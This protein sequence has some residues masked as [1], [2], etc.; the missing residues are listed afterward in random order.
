M[1]RVGTQ[2]SVDTHS[3]D[4][5]LRSLWRERSLA[6][7]SQMKLTSTLTI[8]AS[9]V[10]VLRPHPALAESCAEGMVSTD[11]THCCWPG[12]E[13]QDD[14]CVGAPNCPA[15]FEPTAENRACAKRRTRRWIDWRTAD[16]DNGHR[17]GFFVRFALGYERTILPSVLLLGGTDANGMM[18][19]TR[20]IDPGFGGVG[21][22]FLYGN[23]LGP[24][25][26][27]ASFHYAGSSDQVASSHFPPAR[28]GKYAP[29]IA[30]PLRTSVVS[31][32][33]TVDLGFRFES[34]FAAIEG[35]GGFGLD[36]WDVKSE[37]FGGHDVL[38][39]D[40]PLWARLILKP[41]CEI[42]LVTGI[43]R[44]FLSGS[45]KESARYTTMTLGLAYES[46]DACSDR[47]RNE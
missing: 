13:Y 28:D 31:Y 1:R 41:T 24:I 45:G 39:M 5:A 11:E 8:F 32:G 36:H 22:H 10:V 6:I 38:F 47:K 12:Q 21:G 23:A 29:A 46:N 7:A 44:H 15:G 37:S 14:R 20:L 17:D 16:H 2:R 9:A 33:G 30:G 26:F 35:G 19:G 18:T 43:A 34:H 25:L 27:G 40:T 42:A 4:H 3:L